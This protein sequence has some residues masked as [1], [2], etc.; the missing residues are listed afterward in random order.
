MN[1]KA[2]ESADP[3]RNPV[4]T[5]PFKFVEW[6]QGDHITLEKFDGYFKEGQPY[7][8]GIDFKFLLVDQSRIDGLSAGELDWVDAVPLQ[9]LST[10][11][12]D[13]AV[14]VR[15]VGH[16]GHP[17]LPGAEHDAGAV[18]RQAR[19]AGGRTGDRPR[20][21]SATSRTRAPARWGSKRCRPARPGTT[22]RTPVAPD[23]DKARAAA[24]DAG[25][26]NGLT[27]EYLGLPQY[28]ELLKTGRGRARTAEAD[29]HHMKIKQVDVSVWFDAFVKGNYQITSAY[30]ERT[31]DPD[32]FYAL[33]IRS[34][35]AINTTVYS[36]PQVDDLIDQAR[37]ETDDAAQ[38]GA[39]PADP[40]DRVRRLADHLRALRDDQLPDEHGRHRVHRE[41][42]A[43]APHG[44]RR[45]HRVTSP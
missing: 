18:R 14:H 36:N 31:I 17:R 25:F 1:Q 6:V 8:D 40:A 38:E 39:V 10:L 7:L 5:G 29:R 3:A 15:H 41:P 11:S 13:P 37:T 45:L 9:Q 22:A 24:A 28:P 4:G 2:V 44:E 12:T 43:R 35:G 23:L 34:G 19:P 26:A 32:N 33:V 30:Q 21:R 20:R 42:D 16:G 27:V